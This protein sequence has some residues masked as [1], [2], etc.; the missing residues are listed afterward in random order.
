M[1]HQYTQND[2]NSEPK[3][4]KKWV[5]ETKNKE[6][7]NNDFKFTKISKNNSRE[8]RDSRDKR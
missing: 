3:I 2:I 7:N 8:I 5:T 1:L 6:K 4:L